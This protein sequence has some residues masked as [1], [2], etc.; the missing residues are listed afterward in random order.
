MLN[1]A[2]TICLTFIELYQKPKEL[3]KIRQEWE[4]VQGKDYKYESLVGDAPP[5]LD[6][7]RNKAAKSQK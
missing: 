5:A 7:F 6:Y 4:Q 2:K 3:Q 1:A